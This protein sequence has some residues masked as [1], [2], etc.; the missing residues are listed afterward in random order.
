MA[1]KTLFTSWLGKLV[2]AADARNEADGAAY[3]LG[4][5]GALAQYAATGC[6]NRTYYATAEAQLAELLALCAQVEP[7][8]IAR[9]AIYCRERGHMKDVPALLCAHLCVRAPSLFEQIFPRVITNGRM[10]RTF[11]QI[12]RSGVVGRKSLGTLPRRAVRTWLEGQSDEGILHASVGNA[13]SLADVL[14]LAHPRPKD[15]ARRALYGWVLSRPHDA[16]LL[17]EQVKRFEAFKLDPTGDVPEVPFQL[18]TALSLGQREWSAIARTAGWQMTRMNL[19]TFARHGVFDSPKRVALVA[20]RLRDRE[21]IRRARAL[22]YQLLMAHAM[23]DGLPA[24]ITEAL[25]DALE[26][27]LAN[28]PAIEGGVFILPDVSGSMSSPVTGFRKG[29]TTKVRCIDVAALF[30]AALARKSPGAEILPFAEGVKHARLNPR[31]SVATNAARLAELGGGGTNCAA[32]LEL[33]NQRRAKGAMVIYL[34]DNQSWMDGGRARGTA[35]MQA[36]ET[37]RARNPGARLVCID[38]QPYG[39]TQAK[40]RADVLNVG[41]FSDQVFTLVSAFAKGELSEDH[42]V[43]AINAVP[44]ETT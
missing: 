24:A 3:A 13:P 40:E 32:P 2:P 35:T 14:K 36:W 7:D 6:L 44:L 11:V 30:A 18:L 31:D 4:P 37:F 16:A 34:S 23:S 8:F 38:L 41:G 20:Q 5:K 10:L 28:V 33:L 9:A 12:V 27:S 25:Q 17:P 1:N 19:Q 42:W 43:A 22:P 21:Q 29:A 39:S 26:H 15:D